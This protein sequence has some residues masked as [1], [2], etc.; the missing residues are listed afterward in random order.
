VTEG[1]SPNGISSSSAP[2]NGTAPTV[3]LPDSARASLVLHTPE[4][5]LRAENGTFTVEVPDAA[6]ARVPAHHVGEILVYGRVGLTSAVLDLAAAHGI[7][8]SLFSLGGQW[9]GRLEFAAPDD[10][11]GDDAEGPTPTVTP[12]VAFE[13]V[14]A[15]WRHAADESTRRALARAFVGGKIANARQLMMRARRAEDITTDQAASIDRAIAGHDA[16]LRALESADS[17]DE[18]RGHEGAAARAWF[19]V[20]P[21]ALRPAVRGDFPFSGRNRRPPRDAINALLSYLYALLY[22]EC[23]AAAAAVGLE[24]RLGFLH[25][26]HRGRHSLAL[27]LMEELRPLLADRFAI[28]L[29][30]RRQVR[31][32]HFETDAATGACRLNAEG[33]RALF[34]A[35]ARR[36]METI[37][38]PPEQTTS[39]RWADVPLHQARRLARALR[40]DQPAVYDAFVPGS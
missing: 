7:P 2:R 38:C 4:S 34:T 18:I 32:E 29:L 20:L 1:I 15:Q 28:A 14:A 19:G 5:R 40:N 26:P 13:S 6:P 39:I 12:N 30:N 9:K 21:L 24:T 35:R 36:R 11:G 10:P 17:I 23:I 16:A 37:L 27:D 22:H 3:A 33:R 8:L 25:E 31:P